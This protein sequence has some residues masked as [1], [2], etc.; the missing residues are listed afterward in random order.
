LLVGYARVSTIEQ[1]TDLQMR[2][3]RKAGA[4]RI[5]QEKASA[6]AR[7]PQLEACLAGIER[8]QVLLVW[9]LD[10]LARSLADLLVILERLHAVGAGIRSITEPV[11]TSTPIGTLLIHVLGAVAQFERSLIRERIIAGQAAARARGQRWGAPRLLPPEIED[12]VVFRYIVGGGTI[13]YL[14]DEYGV[15][16]STIRKAVDRAL[17]GF[18]S[19]PGRWR[20][21]SF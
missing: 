6:V 2:A 10:R 4:A 17:I 1:E 13:E 19:R 15:K 14:A 18:P 7:R 9:K 8:G 3:L 20:R 21:L 5:Y 11:D 16:P 12:E